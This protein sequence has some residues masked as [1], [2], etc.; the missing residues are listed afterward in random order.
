[1]YTVAMKQ[2]GLVSI[3]IIILIAAA[4]GL[5]GYLLYSRQ[6]TYPKPQ[7]Q[8]AVSQTLT[9][10]SSFTSAPSP[11]PNQ[12]ANHS[13]SGANRQIYTPEE[14]IAQST[15]L[16]NKEIQIMGV[17]KLVALGADKI[18]GLGTGG[19]AFST[20][21]GLIT[22]TYTRD[23]DNALDKKIIIRGIYEQANTWPSQVGNLRIPAACQGCVN[24]IK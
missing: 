17:I 16:Q 13:P 21:E 14:V 6:V 1:M 10:T 7:N 4:T 3:L 22:V 12:T 11:T 20:N 5:G 19:P 8:I 24:I 18:S 15:K 2:K 23:V 9:P